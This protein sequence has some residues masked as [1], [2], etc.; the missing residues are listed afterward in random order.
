MAANIITL[1]TQADPRLAMLYDAYQEAKEAERA[2]KDRATAA[3]N[4][5]KIAL[6]QAAPG[7]DRVDLIGSGLPVQLVYV[8]STRVDV[9]AF[10]ESYPDLA[11]QLS[12]TSGAW[13]LRT[14]KPL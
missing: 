2:A 10:R 9:K 1:R 5:L 3:S 11:E 12:T 13:Q 6:T 14:G 8:E 4:E 7:A